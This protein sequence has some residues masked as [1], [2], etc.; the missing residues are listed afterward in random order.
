[1]ILTE[2][3]KVEKVLV[4]Y[5]SVESNKKDVESKPKAIRME[6]DRE[7][8]A[9]LGQGDTSDSA[10]GAGSVSER[11]SE[12][13]QNREVEGLQGR[14]LEAC[15]TGAL[16]VIRELVAAKK[17][18]LNKCIAKNVHRDPPL[19]FAAFYG[20]KN[21]VEY[22]IDEEDFDVESKNMF[23]NTPLH[24]AARQGHLKVVKYLVEE[25]SCNPMAVCG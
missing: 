12:T 13:K 1:M 7:M 14:V 18:E 22:L 15:E 8:K 19:H 10:Y 2:H 21:I 24:R 17:V 5:K 20:H 11:E 6:G 23:E 25:K 4:D 9:H 16:D 3:P